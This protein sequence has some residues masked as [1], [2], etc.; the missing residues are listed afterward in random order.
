M[1]ACAWPGRRQAGLAAERQRTHL[2]LETGDLDAADRL[3]V[4]AADGSVTLPPEA[5]DG[6]RGAGRPPRRADRRH[7]S[8]TW[9]TRSAGSRRRPTPAASSRSSRGCAWPTSSAT[10]EAALRDWLPRLAMSELGAARA[11]AAGRPVRRR[12]RAA[13]GFIEGT[14]HP[15]DPYRLALADGLPNIAVWFPP[16]GLEPRLVAAPAGPARLAARP[17]RAWR[18]RRWWPRCRPKPTVARD[19]RELVEGRDLD[20][21]L[22]ALAQRWLGGDGRIV[23]P[24]VRAGGHHG[25]PHRPGRG[26]AV[27]ISS[28]SKT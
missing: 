26:A 12:R 14:G 23:P 5:W 28:T 13:R 11:G 15:D 7:C 18:P 16:A 22:A 1:S 2:A 17:A 10:P 24:P 3:P 21:G 25:P 20:A 27:S 19:V 9:C 6:V 4:I 8:A